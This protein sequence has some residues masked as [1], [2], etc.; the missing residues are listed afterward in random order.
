M[1]QYHFNYCKRIY[2]FI[3]LFT[4]FK[5]F[6]VFESWH[7]NT[8]HWN[9][10]TWSIVLRLPCFPLFDFSFFITP[11]RSPLPPPLPTPHA[12]FWILAS[13]KSFFSFPPIVSPSKY[14]YNS[15]QTPHQKKIP[16][17]SRISHRNSRIPQ[18]C[19]L[20]CFSGSPRVLWILAIMRL[21]AFF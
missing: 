4:A 10:A 7:Q 9:S 18:L 11:T 15:F 21:L 3:L 1:P 5:R 2:R 20:Q 6:N 13:L 16:T 12:Y 8:T 17:L 19:T 14:L